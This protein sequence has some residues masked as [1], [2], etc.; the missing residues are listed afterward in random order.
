MVP[1]DVPDFP[2]HFD[3]GEGLPKDYNIVSVWIWGAT[4]SFEGSLTNSHSGYQALLVG[5]T[6]LSQVALTPHEGSTNSTISSWV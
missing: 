1:V 2:W 5:F 3:R 6:L 4:P